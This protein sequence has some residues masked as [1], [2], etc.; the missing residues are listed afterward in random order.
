MTLD[1]RN[2]RSN[3]PQTNLLTN[4]YSNL[5]IV[6]FLDTI[7]YLRKVQESLNNH[8]PVHH[9]TL[10][11]ATRRCFDTELYVKP[12][13]IE[14]QKHTMH[15][16]LGE[17]AWH[18]QGTLPQ[19]FCV[20]TVMKYANEILFTKR[21]EHSVIEQEPKLAEAIFGRTVEIRATAEKNL[22][23]SEF[24]HP[25]MQRMLKNLIELCK[26]MNEM[27]KC[28]LDPEYQKTKCVESLQSFKEELMQK[29]CH[30]KRV[31]WWMD[32]EDYTEIFGISL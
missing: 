30:P 20:Y 23:N 2:H 25:I 7:H 32:T 1:T 14:C 3:S 6:P 26:N 17:M 31:Q 16:I 12:T 11:A 21:G 28:L 18:P 13:S 29:A 22:L 4:M 10:K 15:E 19:V 9:M 5:R 27:Y 8:I 24:S